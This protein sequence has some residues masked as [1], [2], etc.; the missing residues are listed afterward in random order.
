[1]NKIRDTLAYGK[2]YRWRCGLTNNNLNH[3][4]CDITI[5]DW[6]NYIV[7]QTGIN[8]EDVVYCGDYVIPISPIHNESI[9]VLTMTSDP[10]V[11]KMYYES[12]SK[13]GKLL[14]A[15]SS[16]STNIC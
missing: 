4:G 2:I 12:S 9:I 10:C 13:D 7:L 11:G 8:D 1:M 15:H 3:C 5:P 16:E 6:S 14:L